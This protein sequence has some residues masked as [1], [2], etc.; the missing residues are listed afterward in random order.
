M[1]T[2]PHLLITNDDGINAPGLYSLWRSL[3]DRFDLTIVAPAH[4]QSGAGLS[5]TIKRPIHVKKIPW[6]EGTDAYSVDGTPADCVKLAMH[7]LL[8]RKPDCVVSGINK[9]TNSGRNILYSG[10]VA[11]VIEASMHGIQGIAFSCHDFYAPNYERA[12]AF[13]YPLVEYV[14]QYPFPKGTLLNVTIPDHEGTIQGVRLAKQGVGYWKESPEA[15]L[16][17]EG[18]S[19]YWL[20]GKWKGYEEDEK[21]DVDLVERGY[22]TAVPLCFQQ[23]TDHQEYE[24]RKNSFDEWFTPLLA[25]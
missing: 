20:G 24:Q 6:E 15:C 13:I 4:E 19:Y 12:E 14:L 11:G 17:P 10:T 8:S 21:S 25:R 2:R 9:G 18:Y 7:T 16:H 3:K 5:I 1:S 23:L 22:L